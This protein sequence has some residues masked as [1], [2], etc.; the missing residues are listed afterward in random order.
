MDETIKQ[1][2]EARKN[3]FINSYEITD[4]TLKKEI[5]ELFNKMN[6]LGKECKDV[7]EFESKFATSPLSGEYTKLYTKMASTC[8]MVSLDKMFGKDTSE[9]KEEKIVKEQDEVKEKSD[10]EHAVDESMQPVR[11]MVK[12]EI[13]SELRKTPLGDIEQ[14]SNT[15]SLFNKWLKK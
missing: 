8:E 10:L 14:V 15:S 5:E 4:A 3:A 7:M 6:E 11:R 2:I 1:S 9:T 12:E 13:R